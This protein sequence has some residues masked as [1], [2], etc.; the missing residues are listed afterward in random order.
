MAYFRRIFLALPLAAGLLTAAG[1]DLT[2][3]WAG[4]IPGRVGMQDIAFKFEQKG[5]TLGGKMYLENDETPIAE[6]KV[7]DGQISFSVASDF[8]GRPTKFRFTGSMKDGKVELTRERE[9]G[10]VP[11]GGD[12]GGRGRGALQKQTFTLSKLTT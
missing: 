12:G 3:I 8:N 5:E 4:Q 2:G 7:V 6:G 11:G 9:G 10:A 1:P